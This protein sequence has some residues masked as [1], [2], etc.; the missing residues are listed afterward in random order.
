MTLRT[1]A[2]ISF[3]ILGFSGTVSM[4]QTSTDNLTQSFSPLHG[5]TPSAY[6]CSAHSTHNEWEIVYGR[7]S[8]SRSEAQYSAIHECEHQIGHECVLHECYFVR[9]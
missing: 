3:L 1:A 5:V 2:A 7:T 6:Q 8:W 9:R 4:A